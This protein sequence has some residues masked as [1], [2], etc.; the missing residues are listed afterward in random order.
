MESSDTPVLFGKEFLK[1]SNLLKQI[2]QRTI[3]S[4]KKGFAQLFSELLIKFL[5]KI[6]LL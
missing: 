6:N 5:T 4:Q 1:Q 2:N 3:N